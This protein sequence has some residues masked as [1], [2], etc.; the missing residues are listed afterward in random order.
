MVAINEKEI[1][2]QID[3]TDAKTIL[4]NSVAKFIIRA[5]DATQTAVK[6]YRVF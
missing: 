5:D 6:I 4:G 2:V 1:K 3:T